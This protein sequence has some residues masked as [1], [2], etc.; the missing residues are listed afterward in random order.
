[1]LVDAM[2]HWWLFQLNALKTAYISVLWRVGEVSSSLLLCIRLCFKALLHLNE[3]IPGARLLKVSGPQ[4]QKKPGE[5][6]LPGVRVSAGGSLLTLS[7]QK[8]YKLGMLTEKNRCQQRTQWLAL[9]K[10]RYILKILG[11]D[12]RRNDITIPR[13]PPR[14]QAVSLPSHDMLKDTLVNAFYARSLSQTYTEVQRDL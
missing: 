2:T 10:P 3:I 11:K 4:H 9:C 7:M 13:R 14:F 1:M 12:I 6:L 8:T 5:W